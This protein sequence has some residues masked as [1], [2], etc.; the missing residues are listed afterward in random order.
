MSRRCVSRA[1]AA[2]LL[3]SC[4][5]VGGRQLGD[6]DDE[7]AAADAGSGDEREGGG[8]LGKPD[9][10][11]GAPDASPGAPD[12]EPDPVPVN[13][14]VN[15]GCESG[16]DGW[17]TF[18]G[19]LSTSS[20]ARTG[21]ASCRVCTRAG[22]N[23]STLDDRPE[24]PDGPVGRVY[25][26]SAYVRAEPGGS[27]RSSFMHLRQWRG[28][29]DDHNQGPSITLSSSEWRQIV[30]ARTLE[31]PVGDYFDMYIEQRGV[32]GDCFLIDDVE[33]FLVSDP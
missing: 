4:S 24:R 15:P 22:E 17:G 1:A 7:G 33:L 10:A 16:V 12:A 25:A 32:A 27:T 26:A 5:T 21:A 8:V 3:A 9:A 19:N 30:V 11:R 29:E 18:N 14:A 6:R 2:L 23:F 13:L 31:A 20:V 28:G